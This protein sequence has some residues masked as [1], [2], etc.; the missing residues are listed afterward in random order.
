[1]PSFYSEEDRR[2]GY[3]VAHDRQG[4][5]RQFPLLSVSIGVVTNEFRKIEHVAQV[6]EIGAELKA[7]A[8]SLTKSNYV[9][10]KR[11]AEG[12]EPAP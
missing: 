11:K 6:G 8:K 2:N 3:I 4:A 7:Y 9:M 1:M 10:D 12:P 5:K